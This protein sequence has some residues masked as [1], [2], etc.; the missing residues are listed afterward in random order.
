[1]SDDDRIKALERRVGELEQDR[2]SLF[3]TG[4]LALGGAVITLLGYIWMTKI[5]Q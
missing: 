3:K 1:L 5:G 4:I 2:R